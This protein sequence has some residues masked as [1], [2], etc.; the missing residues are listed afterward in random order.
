MST[1]A[2]LQPFA[3]DTWQSMAAVLTASTSNKDI[4]L[5]SHAAAYSPEAFMIAVAA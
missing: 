4:Y 5:K 2:S 3:A 1:I